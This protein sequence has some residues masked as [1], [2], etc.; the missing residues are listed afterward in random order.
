MLH[1][2][3]FFLL[4]IMFPIFGFFNVDGK[5]SYAHILPSHTEYTDQ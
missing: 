3:K 4:E 2:G 1:A 5:S